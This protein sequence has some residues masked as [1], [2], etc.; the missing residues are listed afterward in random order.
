M[1]D[2]NDLTQ[3]NVSKKLLRFF[4]P[5]LLT[6]L[7]QQIYAVADAVIVGKGLGDNA[8][9]AVGNLSSLFFL[10]AGFAWGMTS[11]FAV[12]IAQK[13]GANDAKG[14]RKSIALSVK[15]SALLAVILTLTGCTALKQVLIV[16]QTGETIMDD[17]LKY[18]YIVFGGIL[19]TVAFS[20]LSAILRSLGDSRTPFIAIVISSLINIVLDC[21]LIFK[22][23]TGVEGAAVA[24][25]LS[26]VISTFL[27]Y[28]KFR[29][30]PVDRISK[31]DF[32]ADR[33]M[34]GLL[35]KNGLPMACMNSVTAVGC[36]V[37]QGYINGCGVAYTAAYS[38]CSRYINLF[39][40]P[41]LTAGI[42]ISSFVSQ[43]Y[44][45]KKP[46]RIKEG[47]RVCVDISLISYVLLGSVMIFL[48]EMLARFMLN[49]PETVALAVQ[50]FKICGASLIFLNLLFVCRNAV[51]GM[52]YP[53]VPTL[54]GIAEMLLR[55][56][57][58]VFLLPVIG[59]KAA[60]VAEAT[61]WGGALLMNGIAY[62]IHIKK[63]S[64]S[65][66][67]ETVGDIK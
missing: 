21:V 23:H 22:F 59:F 30:M 24:T 50:Y 66:T 39:M 64:S 9:A 8:L 51:Q 31:E 27:C 61:A 3:G 53:L 56:P 35:L 5:L 55:I 14:L 46:E 7:L 29:K 63:V 60:A 12:I 38:A 26:Q 44:G 54:S 37:V 36:M 25:V 2:A 45:A 41:S 18:G 1:T 4:F 10:I 33:E 11:G 67:K 6:S 13:Y 62:F 47:V 17:S 16:M 28:F 57:V 49:T 65:L 42:A 15:L 20:M 40:L 43:N 52:G 58:I 19:S 32:A 34:Y 48:P